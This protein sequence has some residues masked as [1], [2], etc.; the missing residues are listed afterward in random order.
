V[1]CNGKN[2]R[3][4]RTHDQVNRLATLLK[5]CTYLTM[6][7][8]SAEV[9]IVRKIWT[10][11]VSSTYIGLR[12][13]IDCSSMSNLFTAYQIYYCP[14]ISSTNHKCKGI[15]AEFSDSKY[16]SIYYTLSLN[17]CILYALFNILFC[18]LIFERQLVVI[19]IVFKILYAP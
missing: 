4:Y 13:K 2:V 3:C 10:T 19:K 6:R 12:W 14:V 15:I 8:L 9:I 7:V 1:A 18:I 11:V 17:T 16:F 5:K